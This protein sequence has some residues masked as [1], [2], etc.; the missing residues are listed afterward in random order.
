MQIIDRQLSR[1]RWSM[2]ISHHPP[3][4]YERTFL[5]GSLRLC[6]RCV[7]MI[8][9]LLFGGSIL[10]FFPALIPKFPHLGHLLMGFG[11]LTLALGIAAF[12][13]NEAGIRVSNNFER[14]V[15]GLALGAT[16]PIAWSAGFWFFGGLLILVLIGQFVSAIL[17]RR[18]NVLDRF[19]AEY[20]EGAEIKQHKNGS[21]L[22]QCG[23]FFC[24]CSTQ[25]LRFPKK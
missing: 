12:V 4:Q 24:A 22:V 18:I 19:V 5:I 6:A 7:G 8:F 17:L 20:L 10:I 23:K 9:G 13:L 3:A 1:P 21:D 15:F 16:L 25:P 2:V 11:F 14:V